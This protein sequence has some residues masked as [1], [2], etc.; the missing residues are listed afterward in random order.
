VVRPA[1]AEAPAKTGDKMN[2]SIPLGTNAMPFKF[3]KINWLAVLVAGL[4][5]FLVGG[6]WYT[7][8]FGQLWIDLQG[9]SPDQVQEMQARMPPPLFFGGMFVC[10]LLLAFILALL[11]TGFD[12]PTATT[13]AVLGLLVWLGPAAAIA[14]T[15][16]LAGGKPIGLYLI[17]TGCQLVYLVLI[18]A[19][20][21]GWRK[22]APLLPVSQFS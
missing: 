14:M 5:A 20:L 3:D 15:G 13:G 10:Y 4:V 8:L 12:R 2:S 17:D 16:H 9:F 6:V 1:A 21:G 11:L 19:L 22:R 18:G 7:A